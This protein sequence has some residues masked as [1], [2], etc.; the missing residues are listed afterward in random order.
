[1]MPEFGAIPC[2]SLESLA[3]MCVLNG[4][5]YDYD[6]IILTNIVFLR[7]LNVYLGEC[8][9]TKSPHRILITI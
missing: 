6:L 2:I 1:M 3:K 5:S 9:I 7:Q 8:S 4:N